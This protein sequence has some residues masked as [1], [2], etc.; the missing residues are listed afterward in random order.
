MPAY[1]DYPGLYTAAFIFGLIIGFLISLRHTVRLTK[2]LGRDYAQSQLDT[3]KVSYATA[4]IDIL[5]LNPEQLE[6]LRRRI[7][8]ATSEKIEKLDVT[9]ENITDIIYQTHV[10]WQLVVRDMSRKYS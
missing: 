1:L 5:R 3:N 8:E 9:G 7:V 4:T 10:D 2:Q 6:G